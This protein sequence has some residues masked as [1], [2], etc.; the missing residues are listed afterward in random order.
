M[1]GNE[2]QKRFRLTHLL[3]G[4]HD[5]ETGNDD[6]RFRLT[7]VDRQS[8]CCRGFVLRSVE[9]LPYLDLELKISF[10]CFG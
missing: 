9:S 1:P 4:E 7:P 10:R 6:F 8:C 5:I 3:E 2:G